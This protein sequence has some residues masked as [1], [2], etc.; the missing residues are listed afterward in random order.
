LGLCSSSLHASSAEPVET[1][2]RFP[3]QNEPRLVSQ[4]EIAT[5][6][7]PSRDVFA[8]LAMEFSATTA[9][10]AREDRTPQ[11]RP[12]RLLLRVRTNLHRRSC[13]RGA[14]AGRRT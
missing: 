8:V 11:T 6:I 2:V 14:F 10:S 13:G 4:F 7:E 12:A 1:F 3:Q 5:V 9:H